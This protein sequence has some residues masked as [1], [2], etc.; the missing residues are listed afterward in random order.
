MLKRLEGLS[1]SV[2]I[3][4]PSFVYIRFGQFLAFVNV[5]NVVVASAALLLY[6]MIQAE[7]RRVIGGF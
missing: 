1:T 5:F 3:A 2:H 7:M 4:S 6:S